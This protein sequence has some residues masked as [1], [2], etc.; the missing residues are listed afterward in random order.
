MNIKKLLLSVFVVLVFCVIF[1]LCFQHC[2][3]AEEV[4]IPTEDTTEGSLSS[5]EANDEQETPTEGDDEVEAFNLYE[6]IKEKIIPVVVGVLTSVSALLATL[7]AVKRGLNSLSETK[8]SFKKE[9][10]ERAESF[11]KESEY[12]NSRVEEM[13]KSLAVVPQLRAELSSLEKSTQ[14]LVKESLYLGRMISLGFSQSKEVVSSG[15]GKKISRLL[16]EC[17]RLNVGEEK[18]E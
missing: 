9:A 16:E 5:N 11:K 3:K 14:R 4:L 7:V 1:L 15:N 6:Y 2:A 8:D 10:K 13:E 18:E 12:L 17:E